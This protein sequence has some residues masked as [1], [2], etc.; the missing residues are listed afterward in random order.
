MDTTRRRSKKRR[1]FRSHRAMGTL[2][3]R[4]N[5]G[6]NNHMPDWM[7]KYGKKRVSCR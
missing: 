1:L 3:K 7:G 4:W 2:Q 6:Q 5:G